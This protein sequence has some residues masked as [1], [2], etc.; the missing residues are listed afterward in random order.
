VNPG[1]CSAAQRSLP[2][3]GPHPHAPEGSEPVTDSRPPRYR[4]GDCRPPQSCPR[5]IRSH[6]RDRG[7]MAVVPQPADEIGH[8][9]WRCSIGG[10]PPALAVQVPDDFHLVQQAPDRQ[11]PGHARRMVPAADECAGDVCGNDENRWAKRTSYFSA[12]LGGRPDNTKLPAMSCRVTSSS[13]R[14]SAMSPKSWS[15]R[16]ADNS[17]GQDPRGASVCRTLGPPHCQRPRPKAQGPV[18]PTRERIQY[19]GGIGFTK[20]LTAD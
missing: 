18:Q 15:S 13:P 3:A 10:R 2:G 9:K 7:I 20:C 12:C 1:R 4:A 5:A 16:T 11:L 6:L 14:S 19:V 8:R 17:A